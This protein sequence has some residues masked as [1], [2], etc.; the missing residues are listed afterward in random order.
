MFP[1]IMMDKTQNKKETM[2]DDLAEIFTYMLV[3]S[4]VLGFLNSR[5]QKKK[6]EE[7]NKS[8]EKL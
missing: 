1:I 4:T 8:Q 6:L 2:Y 3:S 5:K 7:W